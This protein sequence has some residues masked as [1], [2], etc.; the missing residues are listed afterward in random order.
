MECRLRGRNQDVQ[1]IE[2]LIG[3]RQSLEVD[4]L[5]AVSANGFTRPAYEKAKVFGVQTWDLPDLA[6][7]GI[8]TILNPPRLS[9]PVFNR[10][11]VETEYVCDP[12]GGMARRINKFS[13][14]EHLN[15]LNLWDM[16]RDSRYDHNL[17]EE[18][19]AI[20]Y[21]TGSVDLSTNCSVARFTTV[22]SRLLWE[23]TT[24][25]PIRGMRKGQP[26]DNTIV[27]R[28]CLGACSGIEVEMII[29]E[30]ECSMSIDLKEQSGPEGAFIGSPIF[31]PGR[32][33]GGK[34]VVLRFRL[35]SE[36]KI[37]FTHRYSFRE[38]LLQ[39]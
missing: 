8:D 11:R 32:E 2:E 29:A 19:E 4:A 31:V 20:S 25:D 27:A 35:P 7:I 17:K 36:E 38:A 26:E 6:T 30:K 24:V 13:I 16:L 15:S 12:L 18:Q 10:I 23:E 21:M 34:E 14:E 22:R 39:Q 33:L 28:I 37:K 3:R 5:M 9:F 1:W